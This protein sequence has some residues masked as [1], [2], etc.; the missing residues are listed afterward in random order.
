MSQHMVRLEE[1]EFGKDHGLV[2]EAIVTGR[3]VGAGKSF[4]KGLA[5][6][7]DFFKKVMRLAEAC[8]H[9]ELINGMFISPAAQLELVRQRNTERNWGFTEEAFA[10]LGEPPVWPDGKLSAVILDVSLD[11]PQQTFDKAWHFAA[12]VQQNNWRWDGLKSDPDHLRLLPGIT[13]KRCLRWR[14][15]DLGANW[16][17]KNGISSADVRNAKTSP[18]SAILWAASY[19]PKWIQAMDGTNVP[20]VWIPGYQLTIAG[21]GRWSFV[22]CLS[23]GRSCRW[24]GLGADDALSRCVGWAVP[25]FRE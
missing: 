20:Y 12:S 25:S 2:H 5:H 21:G 6:D 13:H 4:W 17:R 7:E 9:A 3:K 19:F 24:V 23:W 11:T 8:G 1:D 15:V 22:P 10:A 16:D 14:V 18:Y